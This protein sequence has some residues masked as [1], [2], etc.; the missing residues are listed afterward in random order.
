MD[1]EHKGAVNLIFVYTYA[2]LIFNRT[3]VYS[4]SDYVPRTQQI[5]FA[6]EGTDTPYKTCDVTMDIQPGTMVTPSSASVWHSASLQGNYRSLH[7]ASPWP[8]VYLLWV[9]FRSILAHGEE[10]W[11]QLLIIMTLLR[12]HQ[13]SKGPYSYFGPYQ[14]YLNVWFQGTPYKK[15][16]R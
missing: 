13:M 15:T 4:F 6:L 16:L 14:R 7:N 2:P 1:H 9:I 8:H 3:I 10:L 11:N 12:S 5:N